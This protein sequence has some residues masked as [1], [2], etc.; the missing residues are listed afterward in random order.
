MAGFHKVAGWGPDKDRSP[1]DYYPTPP[2]VTRAL[3]G[4]EEFPGPI[5]EPCAGRGHV[6][7][8]LRNAGYS[9]LSNEP[10]CDPD[11]WSPELRMDFLDG[12][13]IR[14]C[15]SIVTNPPYRTAEAFIRT[16]IDL[17]FEKHAWL[18][19]FQFVE[20]AERFPLFRDH[21]PRRLWVFSR[22]VQISERGLDN[23]LG[24]MIVYAWWIWERGY[25]GHPEI[26]W[27]P[28]DVIARRKR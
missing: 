22:R 11:G 18:L 24:G 23:P 5:L 28:P 26:R 16:A 27:F 25:S 20:S 1:H 13:N 3:L 15:K 21:P 7:R 6:V 19:R 2:E 9:V 12:W 4:V 8:E 17:D 14:G 10:Y